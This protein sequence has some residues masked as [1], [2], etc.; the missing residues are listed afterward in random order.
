MNSDTRSQITSRPASGIEDLRTAGDLLSQAWLAGSPHASWTPGDLS[1]WFA[2]AWP[3]EL[4]E[5]LRLWS[6]DGRPIAWSWHEPHDDA[7]PA[8]IEYHAW[9]GD[10]GLDIE[11][12]RAILSAATDGGGQV[13][14]SASGNDADRLELFGQFGFARLEP[15]PGAPR[16]LTGSL[17]QLTADAVT[18]D[19]PLADGYRIRSLAGPEDIQ[20]RVEVHRAA[21]AP[22]RMSVDKYKRLITLP[23]YRFEDDLVVEASDGSFAAFTMA[24]WDP[25]A[26]VGEFEPVGTH[27]DHQRR[28]L[29]KALLAHALRR[30]RRA[31]ARLNLV[32]SSADNVASEALYQS[33][34][35]TRTALYRR[36]RR[37]ASRP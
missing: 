27:P 37:P 12:G 24:W 36:Y 13:D 9:S 34:G 17:Y 14:A 35:F 4:G 6:I 32:Y 25:V 23:G 18:P 31:G 22:S 10:R 30:Y 1:W 2:Q 5:H 11:V 33:V 15:G 16:H 21:F 20:A 19:P 7:G 26:R 8:E 3:V 28:G 29:A